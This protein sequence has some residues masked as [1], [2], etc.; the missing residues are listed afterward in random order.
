MRCTSRAGVGSGQGKEDQLSED[1]D[2]ALLARLYARR[3]VLRGRLPLRRLRL[4]NSDWQ[5]TVVF[6]GRAKLQGRCREV[7][8][9]GPAPDEW[10]REL[11][12]HARPETRRKESRQ[13]IRLPPQVRPAAR[14]VFCRLAADGGQQA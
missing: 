5:G 6:P 12:L 4:G 3:Y 13:E 9:R 2:P 14:D 8:R 1:T 11:D 10:I 7:P